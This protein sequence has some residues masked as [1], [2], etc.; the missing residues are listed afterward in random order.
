MSYSYNKRRK[1]ERLI[2]KI[3]ETITIGNMK[4]LNPSNRD[5]KRILDAIKEYKIALRAE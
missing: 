1:T 3:K 2:N 5:D 4:N